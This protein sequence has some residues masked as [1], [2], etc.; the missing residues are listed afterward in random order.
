MDV[1]CVILFICKGLFIIGGYYYG[2]LLVDYG[3]GI[4]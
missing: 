4:V 1:F 2:D 3:F